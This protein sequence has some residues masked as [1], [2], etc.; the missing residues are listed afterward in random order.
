MVNNVRYRYVYEGPVMV[1]DTL[2]TSKVTRETVAANEKRAKTNIGYRLKEE[3]NL[4]PTARINLPGKL[5]RL[6]TIM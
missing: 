6:E 2:V 1:F 5:K 4:A 3:L